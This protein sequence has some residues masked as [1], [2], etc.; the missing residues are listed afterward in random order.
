LSPSLPTEPRDEQITRRFLTK[1]VRRHGISENL[2]I[3][4]SEAKA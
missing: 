1:A 4:A 2:T 3:D